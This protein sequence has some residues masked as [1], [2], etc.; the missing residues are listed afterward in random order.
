MRVVETE[1]KT[2]EE[3]VQAA[4]AELGLEEDQ[5]DVEVLSKEH[6]GGI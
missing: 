3:A 1:A 2:Q 4:L 5:V 6:R